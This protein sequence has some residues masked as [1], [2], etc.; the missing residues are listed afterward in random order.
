MGDMD[1]SG[2]LK[3]RKG[4]PAKGVEGQLEGSE[5]HCDSLISNL[6]GLM[7]ALVESLIGI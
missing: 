7:V 6:L 2:G 5:S 1:G 4:G 3:K